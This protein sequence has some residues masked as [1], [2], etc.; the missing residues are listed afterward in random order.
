M[1]G[2]GQYDLQILQE[3]QSIDTTLSG[4]SSTL[5]GLSSVVSNIADNWLPILAVG[6]LVLSVISVV[7]WVV[8]L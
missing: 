1:Y 2:T 4:V 5:S 3:L 8:K 6:V 7:K